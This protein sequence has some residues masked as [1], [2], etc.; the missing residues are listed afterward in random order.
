MCVLDELREQMDNYWG[1]LKKDQLVRLSRIH[2]IIDDF[3]A[4][5]PGLE[6]ETERC[7]FCGE[8]LPVDVDGIA[9][10]VPALAYDE[11]MALYG[12]PACAREAN[13]D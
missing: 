13:D 12:C 10:E 4:A 6:D 1:S 2:A 9:F 3:E 5:H 8:P 7:D 11:G